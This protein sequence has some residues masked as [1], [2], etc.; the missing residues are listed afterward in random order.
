[1]KR[2]FWQGD[3]QLR[4]TVMRCRR[5]P[6][7]FSARRAT[8]SSCMPSYRQPSRVGTVVYA[9]P[10]NAVRVVLADVPAKRGS[11]FAGERKSVRKK[12]GI[13]ACF[14]RAVV[15]DAD[16]GHLPP[17]ARNEHRQPQKRIG[18]SGSVCQPNAVRV[19]LAVH[20]HLFPFS[21]TA[22]FTG[23]GGRENRPV[24]SAFVS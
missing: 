10:Q 6:L 12:N 13:Y 24:T 7:I 15:A 3:Y 2:A 18:G 1:M 5:S 23:A 17:A 22:K 19:P 20:Q 8:P 11:L 4:L 14:R 9:V 21:A 16:S